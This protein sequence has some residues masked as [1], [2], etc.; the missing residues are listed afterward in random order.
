M[1][2]FLDLAG[3]SWSGILPEPADE[4]KRGPDRFG[5]VEI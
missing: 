1:E 3:M 2:V 5:G 4:C